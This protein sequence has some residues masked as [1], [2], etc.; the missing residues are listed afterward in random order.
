MPAG[1]VSLG[2]VGRAAPSVPELNLFRILELRPHGDNPVEVD[3]CGRVRFQALYN[4][5]SETYCVTC[6]YGALLFRERTNG[7]YVPRGVA[8]LPRQS[9][10]CRVFAMPHR[11]IRREFTL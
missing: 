6:A 3:L 2:L 5:T 11:A 1:S 7:R 10:S 9:L 4:T 8:A